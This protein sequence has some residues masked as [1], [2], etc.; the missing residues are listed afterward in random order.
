MVLL[1]MFRYRD[2]LVDWIVDVMRKY[3]PVEEGPIT[4]TD[5]EEGRDWR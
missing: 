1:P 2:V 4:G 3:S 5:G